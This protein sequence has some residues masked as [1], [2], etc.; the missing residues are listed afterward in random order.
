MVS[1]TTSWRRTSTGSSISGSWATDTR[2]ARGTGPLARTTDPAPAPVSA[3]LSGVLIK[4]VGIYVLA[5]LV[6]NVFGPVA[7]VLEL[8]CW[9]GLASMVVGALAVSNTVAL[10]RR[11]RA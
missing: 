11:K 5:R 8:L 3:L 9:L 6:F 7:G 2:T 1:S 4:A 10:M